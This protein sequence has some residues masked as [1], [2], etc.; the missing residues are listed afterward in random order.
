[1]N[2]HRS[3]ARARGARTYLR[4]LGGIGTLVALGALAHLGCAATNAVPSPQTGSDTSDVVGVEDLSLLEAELGLERD[5]KNAS[6]AWSRDVKQGACYAASQAAEPHWEFR[7]YKTGAAFFDKK[8]DAPGKGDSRPVLCVDVEPDGDGWSMPLHP[9]VLDAVVRYHLGRT[10]GTDSAMGGARALDFERGWL[11]GHSNAFD[12]GVATDYVFGEAGDGPEG[13]GVIAYR[14]CTARGG[15]AD[16]CEGEAQAAC[17][18]Q[19]ELE[20][21]PLGFIPWNLTVYPQESTSPVQE[22][23]YIDWSTVRSIEAFARSKATTD[24]RFNMATDPVGRFLKSEPAGNVTHL[25][26]EHLDVHVAEDGTFISP[27]S[28]DTNFRDVAIATF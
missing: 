26:Y 1:M 2:L 23:L 24:D 21:G 25:R 7:R 20:D 17:V 15:S 22:R 16:D 3:F 4:H 14:E 8:A 19:G 9:D 10:S 11:A 27:K 12:C 6:G 18:A 5:V 28:S 13:K